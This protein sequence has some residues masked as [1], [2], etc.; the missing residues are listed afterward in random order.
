MK[1]HLPK[2]K[3]I[4]VGGSG[5]NAIN[6]MSEKGVFGVELVAVNTDAQSLKNCSC[7]QRILIGKNTTHG[8]GA[9]MD[10]RLGARAAQENIDDL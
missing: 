2:I 9:G 3:V 5:V 7:P 6:R 1:N 10:V 8:W 4:G